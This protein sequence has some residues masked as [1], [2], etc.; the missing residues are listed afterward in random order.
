MAIPLLIITFTSWVPSTIAVPMTPVVA[1][2]AALFTL[3]WAMPPV[4][5]QRYEHSGVVLSATAPL[6][7]EL[8]RQ[9][10]TQLDTTLLEMFGST[11]TCVIATRRTSSMAARMRVTISR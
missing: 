8:A 9:I 11:E 7:A 2:G 10:E 5:A 6:D 1:D 4:A 3:L